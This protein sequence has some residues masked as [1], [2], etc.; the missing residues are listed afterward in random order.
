MIYEPLSELPSGFQNIITTSPNYLETSK[1]LG[2]IRHKTNVI[3]L[4]IDDP[5]KLDAVKPQIS[6][7]FEPLS[8]SSLERC[9]ITRD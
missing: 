7:D 5:T 9:D 3:P 8:S 6:F 4:G 2:K 1:L